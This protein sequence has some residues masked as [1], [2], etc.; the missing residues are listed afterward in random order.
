[1]TVIEPRDVREE[2][3]RLEAL[4][5]GRFGDDYIARNLSAARGREAFWQ[6][7]L[8][9]HPMR[10]VLEVGCNVGANLQ[11]IAGGVPHVT[12]VDVNH[13]ALER[14]RQAVP[15]VDGILAPARA[16]PFRG[17]AFDLVF[18][19]GVLIHQPEAALPAVIDEVVRCSGR[20]VLSIEYFAETTVEVPYRGERDA[21]FKRNY[22]GLFAA[23][24]P[25]LALIEQGELHRDAGWDEVTYWL[26]E[27]VAGR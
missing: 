8:R 19:A 22:G 27:K 6:G 17:G 5:G 2:A 11:W 7:L 20:Y 12:G 4:W 13:G 21:L 14:L 18:T 1:V 25:G 16:L 23:R 10:S 24:W 9:A 3:R 26:F 15:G